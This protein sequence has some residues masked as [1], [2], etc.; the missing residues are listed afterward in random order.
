MTS[1]FVDRISTANCQKSGSF[2]LSKDM[3]AT[4]FFITSLKTFDLHYT[5]HVIEIPENNLINPRSAVILFSEDI[6]V[7]ARH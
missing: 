7:I 4:N 5:M 2:F 3:T 1:G 6:H